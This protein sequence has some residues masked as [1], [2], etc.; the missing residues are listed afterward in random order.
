MIQYSLAAIEN[1]RC[2]IKSGCS[3]ARNPRVSCLRRCDVR[4]HVNTS[5]NKSLFQ[6][7]ESLTVVFSVMSPHLLFYSIFSRGKFE[8]SWLSKCFTWTDKKMDAIFREPCSYVL[9]LCFCPKMASEVISSR[10]AG[11]YCWC[12]LTLSHKL[13]SGRVY[14]LWARWG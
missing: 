1:H 9:Q 4:T 8:V 12:T 10:S 6:A 5:V 7:L 13:F 3:Y 2:A 14:Y 11:L